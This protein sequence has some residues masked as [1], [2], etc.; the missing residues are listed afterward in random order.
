MKFT[1]S[2]MISSFGLTT[3]LVFAILAHV[4]VFYLVLEI[5]QGLRQDVTPHRRDERVFTILGRYQRLGSAVELAGVPAFQARNR[6]ANI[7]AELR[8][9]TF[10]DR[11]RVLPTERAYSLR[12]PFARPLSP[13]ARVHRSVGLRSVALRSRHSREEIRRPPAHR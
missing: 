6:Q 13:H 1:Q 3:S 5:G 4:L 2:V 10:C 12:R 8:A 7:R 9:F 11:E